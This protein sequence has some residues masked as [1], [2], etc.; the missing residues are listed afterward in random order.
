M[1]KIMKEAVQSSSHIHKYYD[2]AANLADHMFEGVYHGKSSHPVDL[3]R[4]LKRAQ[5]AG[6]DRWDGCDDADC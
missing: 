3:D 2:I 5:D 1:M 6:V 4:V